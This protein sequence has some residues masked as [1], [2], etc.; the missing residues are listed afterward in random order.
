MTLEPLALE[1]ADELA[2]AVA[3]GDLWKRWYTNIPAPEQMHAEIER[4]LAL[5]AAGEV[6]PWTVRRASDGRAV[7]MTTY[8]HIVAEHRR[9]EIGSTWLAASAQGTGIN[10]EAK[11]HLLARAFDTLGCIAVE[12]RTHWHNRQSRRAIAALGAKQ[13]GVLRSHQ[14][15]RD[16]TL[17]D[18]VVF[19][20]LASEWPTVR[21]ALSEKLARTRGHASAAS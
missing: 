9:L 1:H 15:G 12:F 7:G 10:T 6:V 13:D 21:L 3:E 2:E 8:L 5:H 18:T 17:R 11:L 4:R 14:I 19:S 16:G 20:I